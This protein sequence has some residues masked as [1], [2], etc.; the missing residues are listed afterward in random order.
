MLNKSTKI[1]FNTF[2]SV[3]LFVGLSFLIY[4]QLQHQ[5]NLSFALE[6]IRQACTGARLWIGITL[7]LM[8]VPNWLLEAR[9]WQLL[10]NRFEP[11]SLFRALQSVL[12][13]LSLG[14]N[15]PNRIGEYAGRIMLVDPRHRLEA[16]SVMIL[17]SLSQL[18]ITLGFGMLGLVYEALAGRMHGMAHG[19]WLQSLAVFLCGMALVLVIL[20]FRKDLMVNFFTYF[21]R[22]RFLV[23]AGRAI[24]MVPG[25]VLIQLLVLSVLRYG[26][27][28]GQYLALLRFLGASVPWIAGF[29][30]ISLIYMI[31]AFLPTVAIAEIGIRGELNIYF[32]SAYTP[33][34]L[35]IVSAAV[36]IWLTNLMIPAFVGSMLWLKVKTIR[37]KT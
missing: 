24:R 12:A 10:L 21:R 2:I 19:W 7:L 3:G 22:F 13:G 29:F 11:V 32:L 8:V 33:N 6:Q 28:S 26:I 30:N 20:Y 5:Q 36:I 35:A 31:M 15:T 27:F 25:K 18:I 14:I 37:K 34:T 9:K 23:K 1:I 17:S 4:R 16:A